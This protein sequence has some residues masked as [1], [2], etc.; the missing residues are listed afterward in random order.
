VIDSKA[1][2]KVGPNQDIAGMFSSESNAGA[3]LTI[4]GRL[5]I[6]LH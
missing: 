1:M 4:Q 3:L 5:L 6:Q 2:R